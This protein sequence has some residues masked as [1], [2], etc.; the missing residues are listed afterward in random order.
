MHFPINFRILFIIQ[1]RIIKYTRIT[2][3]QRQTRSQQV[4]TNLTSV[5]TLKQRNF[6][7]LVEHHSDS[8]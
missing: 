5:G 4:S 6:G 8:L 1:L 3:S 2:S 7:A